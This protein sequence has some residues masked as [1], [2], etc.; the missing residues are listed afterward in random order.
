[1]ENTLLSSSP[2]TLFLGDLEI[3]KL[4]YKLFLASISKQILDSCTKAIL[5]LSLFPERD[6]SFFSYTETEDEVSLIL[7]E[8]SL[9]YFSKSV[10]KVFAI[11]KFN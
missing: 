4:P 8:A 11:I 1:M 10:G 5:K 9:S 7:D 6:K 2:K 3:T